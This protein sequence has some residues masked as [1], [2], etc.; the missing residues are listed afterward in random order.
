[1]TIMTKAELQDKRENLESELQSSYKV[2]SLGRK[3]ISDWS[4][5]FQSDTFEAYIDS[6]GILRTQIDYN[7]LR[8][9]AIESQDWEENPFE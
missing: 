2:A 8:K 1:M 7:Y 6:G 5:I 3:Q 9:L 4:R